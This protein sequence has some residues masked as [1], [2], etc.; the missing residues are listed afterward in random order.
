LIPY[1]Q[2]LQ[3]SPNI[4]D[5][6][7]R[8]FPKTLLYKDSYATGHGGPRVDRKRSLDLS[9]ERL[10]VI[11]QADPDL[12]ETQALAK[13]LSF[14]HTWQDAVSDK[15]LEALAQV[16][17]S[18]DIR[19]DIAY[20]YRMIDYY[21]SKKATRTTAETPVAPR[22]AQH[23]DFGYFTLI[24]ATHP[25]LQVRMKNREN[26]KLKKE[27]WYHLPDIPVGSAILLFGW[28]TEICS[29]GRI[30]GVLHRVV[31]HSGDE[32]QASRISAVLFC[33]P[34]KVDT[35]LE[36]VLLH[37]EERRN[38]KRG[39]S[40]GDLHVQLVESKLEKNVFQ[41]LQQGIQKNQNGLLTKL[42]RVWKTTSKSKNRRQPA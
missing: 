27:C 36:P 9:P 29:N 19:H 22:L 10:Q 6:L 31:E 16:I 14:F 18:Q 17:G 41:W 26:P 35:V 12:V 23:R 33:A 3:N 24:Q 8:A 37:P 20:N 28:C 32:T 15:I 25:G 40:V 34:T 38:Y 1:L 11:A 13:P 7:N 5:R 42:S 21:P 39:V 4:T 2:L 30:P